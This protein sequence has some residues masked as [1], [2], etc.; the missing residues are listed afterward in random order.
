MTIVVVSGKGG[1]GKTTIATNLAWTL[2]HS[3]NPVTILDCDVENPNCHIFLHP[4]INR[5]E[6]CSVL[7]PSLIEELCTGCGTCQDV[8]MYDAMIV[9]KGT[10]LFLP[11]RCRS[12]GGCTLFC[13]ENALNEEGKIIGTIEYGNA[14]DIAFVHGKL[15]SGELLATT[16]IR[17]VKK[18]ISQEGVF[19]IDAP[20]GTSNSVIEAMNGADFVVLVA[21]PT[22]F[23]IH[24]LKRAV[25]MVRKCNLPFGVVVNRYDIGNQDVYEY[26]LVEDIPILA[27]IPNEENIAK[28]Y[29]YGLVMSI[30]LPQHRIL[31]MNLEKSITEQMHLRQILTK[32]RVET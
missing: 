30:A 14:H 21:E 15:N 26:C 22:P 7:V 19:I 11:E 1:T 12:C 27:Q 6:Q 3:G 10:V 20:A 17:Q 31:F 9:L 18:S 2:S 28:T 32:D 25:D 8:C 5:R 16:L 23:G 24:G 4:V 29:S 13:P